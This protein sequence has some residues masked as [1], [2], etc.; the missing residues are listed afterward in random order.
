MT[1]TIFGIE[2]SIFAI[3]VLSIPVILP[4]DGLEGTNFEMVLN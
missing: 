2:E 1:K 4:P 3:T